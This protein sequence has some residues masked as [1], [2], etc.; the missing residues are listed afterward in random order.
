MTAAGP[1]ILPDSAQ[2]ENTVPAARRRLLVVTHEECG[3]GGGAGAS[4]IIAHLQPLLPNG[5]LAEAFHIPPGERVGVSLQRLNESFQPGDLLFLGSDLRFPDPGRPD[6]YGNVMLLLHL[7]LSESRSAG[8]ARLPVLLPLLGGGVET[9]LR[10]T[11]DHLAVLSPGVFTLPMPLSAPPLQL[12]V[13]NALAWQPPTDDE[14]WRAAIAPFIVLTN[15]DERLTDHG[16]RNRAGVEK[17]RVEFAGDILT[18]PISSEMDDDLILKKRRFRQPEMQI[19]PAPQAADKKWSKLRQRC[20]GRRFL[21]IDDQHD[22]GWSQ[23]LF[24]GIFGQQ[25]SP[26]GPEIVTPETFLSGLLPDGGLICLKDYHKAEAFLNTASEHIG[27]ELAAWSAADD[28]QDLTQCQIHSQNVFTALNVSA[29]FLDLRLQNEDASRPSTSDL[30]GIRLLRHIRK[31]FP[32]LPVIVFTASEKAFSA[33]TAQQE[34]A[35]SYWIKGRSSGE[36]LREA[37]RACL[38]LSTVMERWLK[39]RMVQVRT[40]LPAFEFNGKTFQPTAFTNQEK[41]N[42]SDLL[43]MSLDLFWQAVPEA[44]HVNY[45]YCI[46][47]AGAV[48][49]I[50]FKNLIY[51]T[52]F[53]ADQARTKNNGK[54]SPN[55]TD[56]ELNSMGFTRDDQK[57]RDVRNDFTHTDRTNFCVHGSIGKSQNCMDITLKQLLS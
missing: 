14:N 37:V 8:C 24:A 42:I 52:R 40:T 4:G 48:Q 11:S 1:N 13:V 9:C 12:A 54:N 45:R 27:S 5:V 20:T 53:A 46:V 2:A 51:A 44:S 56:I 55:L 7:R 21:Y 33:E 31:L 10:A 32:Y 50:R 23:V 15:S 29:V 6:R 19:G 16:F 30:S 35:N 38:T 28:S 26:G 3:D 36:E 49:E 39:V 41:S 47:N 43:E 22:E 18:A 25:P 17:L 34:K 57:I